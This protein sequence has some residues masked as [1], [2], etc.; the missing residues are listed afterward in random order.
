MR[1]RC[2]NAPRHDLIVQSHDL[3]AGDLPAKGADR[4]LAEPLPPG[5]RRPEPACVL[6]EERAQQLCGQIGNIAFRSQVAVGAQILP[7]HRRIEGH[8]RQPNRHVIEQLAGPF[9]QAQLGRDSRIAQRQVV[10]G[11]SVYGTFPVKVTCA[12][13]PSQH[14]CCW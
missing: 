12:S 3:F 14:A 10:R 5:S 4:P 2:S 7:R 6:A 9:G 1:G 8:R 11:A 13:M